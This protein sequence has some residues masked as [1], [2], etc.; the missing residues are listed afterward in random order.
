[1]NFI[2]IAAGF[3]LLLGGGE[4][5]VR[6][7]IA[8]ARRFHVSPLVIG[9]TVVGF[10]TSA[11]ELVVGVDAAL[12]G[13]SG[14]IVGNVIG[15]NLANMMLILGAAAAVRA[16]DVNPDALRRDGVAVAAATVLFAAV[17]LGGAAGLFQGLLMVAA[18]AGFIAWTLWSDMRRGD[19]TAARH[20][21]SVEQP[22]RMPAG[23]WGMAAAI[24]FGIG[25]LIVGAELLVAGATALAHAAGVSEEV[26]GLTLVA[27]GTSLPEL[28]TSIVAALRRQADMCLGN[29]LGS[30]I[31][32][33][34]GV[35]GA[36]A[37]VAPI[38][39]HPKILAFDLWALVA[40]TALMIAVMLTG[41][42]ISRI[43]GAALLVLYAT[44]IAVQFVGVF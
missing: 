42:R 7:S 4:A 28:A 11:P 10:G 32:N 16:I 27:L 5:L 25:F 37:M 14:I 1:M 23:I 18:L 13:A 21:R 35:T 15:S 44:Y 36:A 33:L 30:N 24:V 20:E 40:V 38:A 17:A 8:L 19:A 34:L 3:V 43:E 26:I 22:G 29:V 9:V 31:F 39:F 6:G 41:R 2:L 12:A